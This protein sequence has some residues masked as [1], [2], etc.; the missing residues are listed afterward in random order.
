VTFGRRPWCED[1]ENTVRKPTSFPIGGR[2]AS[3]T[4]NAL[5]GS[6]RC[7]NEGNQAGLLRQRAE[8]I[9][10]HGRYRYAPVIAHAT[11]GSAALARAGPTL[12]AAERRRRSRIRHRMPVLQ[13]ASPKTPS[14]TSPRP[15]GLRER[16]S[17]G[18]LSYSNSAR[19]ASGRESR[20]AR[21]L[22]LTSLVSKRF[23]R[24]QPGGVVPPSPECG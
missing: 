24:I 9:E 5:G 11:I 18:T 4:A 20:C 21:C 23:N 3:G 16:S 13:Q 8:E 10:S 17:A 22:V 6:R 1:R 15:N 7:L 19:I 14:H 2:R 12:P